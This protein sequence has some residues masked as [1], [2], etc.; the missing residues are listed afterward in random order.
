MKPRFPSCSRKDFWVPAYIRAHSPHFPGHVVGIL[1]VF[2]G[3]GAH[4]DY[5]VWVP[6]NTHPPEEACQ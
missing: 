2:W 1:R 6:V 5:F 4:W 3:T